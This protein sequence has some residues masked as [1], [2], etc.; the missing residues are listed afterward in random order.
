[1]NIE[2]LKARLRFEEEENKKLGFMLSTEREE[3]KK[4]ENIL[5]KINMILDLLL[6]DA[7]ERYNS[8]DCD[9]YRE[10]NYYQGQI[11]A[12]NY[13]RGIIERITREEERIHEKRIK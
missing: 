2:R 13:F 11:D 1:M 7:K 8:T 5:R 4:L 12:L 3:C 6:I 9:S 10:L